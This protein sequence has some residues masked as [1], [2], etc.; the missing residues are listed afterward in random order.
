MIVNSSLLLQK[1][2]R[3]WEMEKNC[4]VQI[5]GYTSVY[6]VVKG[7]HMTWEE[8]I[9]SALKNGKNLEIKVM[10]GNGS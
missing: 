10:N 3:A 4:R 2:L 9:I 8:I 1:A 5:T 7:E 6:Y